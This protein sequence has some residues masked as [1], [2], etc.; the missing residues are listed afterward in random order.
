MRLAILG[1]RGIPARYGGFETF[2]ERLA[3]GLAS[4]G[5]DVTVYCEGKGDGQP[6]TFEGVHLEYIPAPNVGPVSTVLY[7]ARCLWDAR[8]RFDVVYMLGYGSAPF[9]LI[10]RMW[11]RE[12]WINP[13]GLE[14]AR[15]KWNGFAKKYFQWMEWTS[16]RVGDRII[17]D[18]WAIAEELSRR[19]GKLRSCSVIPY[20]CEVIEAPPARHGLAE[21]RVDAENYYL[22][23]CRLEPENHVLEILRAFEQC[24]SRRQLLVTGNLRRNCYVDK[25]RA[26]KDPRIRMIGTVYERDKLASLRYHSFAY[27]HG[28]SVGGTNPSLLEAMGCGNLIFAHDNPFNRETLGTCGLYFGGVGELA[29]A[30]ATAETSNGDLAWMRDAA[31]KRARERYRWSDVIDSYE[32]LLQGALARAA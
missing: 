27:F 8:E 32:R 7:D 6:R 1:T 14:W 22:I 20:G 17:A 9:C 28:H 21:W 15:A 19:H 11:H 12:V 29:E 13:D 23:V 25:L 5:W 26:I 10:P 24:D 3:T 18:A 2:A 31:R 4:R 16:V 30:I